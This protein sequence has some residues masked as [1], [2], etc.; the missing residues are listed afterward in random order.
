[1]TRKMPAQKPGTSF[2]AYG[3]PRPFLDAVDRRFGPIVWDL[4][5]NA[6][7]SVCGDRFF[8]PGSRWGEDSLE[9]AWDWL[10]GVRT[11]EDLI[12]LNPPF[13]RIGPWARKCEDEA[14]YGARILMLVPAAVGSNWFAKY[15]ERS[16]LVLPIRP[17][18]A[19]VGQTDP[20][21]KDL[22]L[23]AWNQHRVRVELEVG[24]ET[25]R[26]DATSGAEVAA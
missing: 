13:S 1:M 11:G 5:A 10:P 19:F 12:W 16:A 9:R 24:F 3:T 20:Y 15:V 18:L 4:A 25:W 7:N 26:W 22:M 17:R 2:Q 14:T 6:G 8:G 23:C 21:P